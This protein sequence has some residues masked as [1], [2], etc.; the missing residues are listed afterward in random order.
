[1]LPPYSDLSAHGSPDSYADDL[2]QGPADFLYK[3][4]DKK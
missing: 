2:G 1:M 3:R 4:E